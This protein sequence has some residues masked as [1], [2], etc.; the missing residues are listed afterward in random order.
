MGKKIH[1]SIIQLDFITF[2][3]SVNYKNR[4][5]IPKIWNKGSRDFYDIIKHI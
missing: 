2:T 1:Y 5:I 3:S 4:T